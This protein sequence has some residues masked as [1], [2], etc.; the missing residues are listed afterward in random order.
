MKSRLLPAIIGLLASLSSGQGAILAN[1]DF[2]HTGSGASAVA[3]PNSSD[4][5]SGSVAGTFTLSGG[6]ATGGTVPQAAISTS[7]DQPFIRSLSLTNSKA[8][9][10]GGN[11]YF[12]FSLTP[13]AGNAYNMTTLAFDFG[14]SNAADAT[15]DYTASLALQASIGGGAFF[16]VGSVIDKTV[17]A[18]AT[19]G[20][21]LSPFSIDLSS[22]SAFQGVTDPVVFRFYLYS[23]VSVDNRIVR[24][25]NVVLNGDLI[26]EP[27]SAAFLAM[28][29]AAAG[30]YR[31][32][33]A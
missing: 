31:R 16:D 5:N 27:S 13:N 30:L 22:V 15:L 25:D 21:Q 14:G 6:T 33:R 2:T 20:N 18:N 7:T 23:S 8:G 3:N 4:S 10:I 26:P 9:A 32:R 12:S 28:V 17:L 1:Y 11:D 29:A 19:S 24:M